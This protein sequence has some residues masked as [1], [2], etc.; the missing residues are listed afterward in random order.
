MKKLN[1]ILFFTLILGLSSFGQTTK[2][3]SN[4]LLEK[5]IILQTEEEFRKAKV[6]NDVQ[7]ID[8]ILADD[9]K[10]FNQFGDTSDKAKAKSSWI[11][12]K[13]TLTLDSVSVTLESDT[14]AKV[15]G[16]MKE[17]DIPMSFE[18]G[19]IKKDGK[20]Q[21]V[22]LLQKMIEYK[23]TRGIGK[24]RITGQLSGADGVA[25]SL[26]RNSPSN[27]TPV[28][29]N[30]AI[31]KN[32]TFTMEGEA[33]EYPQIVFLTTPGKRERSSFFLENAEITITGNVDSLS[34][35]TV[36]GSKTQDEY[37][38][39]INAINTFRG[40]FESKN[41]DLKSA[42]ENK[43]TVRM[44]QIKKEID[45]IMTEVNT[46][47]KNFV[48]NNPSSYASPVILQGLL[49]TTD[50]SEFE[51]LVK[52][53]DSNVGRT[54]EVVFLKRR[55]SERKV[56]EIG[57]KAPDF[58][59][60]DVNG[61]PVSLS[62]KIGTKLLLIDFWAAWCAPCRAE[63]PNLVKVYNEFKSKGFDVLGVSLDRKKEDWIQAIAKDNLTWTQVSDLLYWNSPVARSYLVTAIPANFLLDKNGIIIAKNIRGEALSA[64]V[65]EL[66]DK[67]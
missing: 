20:W 21:I 67:K 42:R 10:G 61:V 49:N 48:R 27:G 7:T 2:K 46:I 30:A 19:L 3:T 50:H 52:N 55:I 28:N 9:Y 60:N 36:A 31:V 56:V 65:K 41:K 6:D 44:D 63:N 66:L 58:T 54:P 4:D 38:T 5:K 26:I 17:D 12:R 43:D 47:Q 37:L 8:K 1:S 16:I 18:H 22:S 13:V 15:K 23:G 64:K 35:A 32:G 34:K 53:L 29:L 14:S 62:S 40:S 25:F 45:M 59:L 39:C 51:S 11:N 24:Y 57:Q 33:I